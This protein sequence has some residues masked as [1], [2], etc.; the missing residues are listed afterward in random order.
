[1][2]GS[3]RDIVGDAVEDLEF[4]GPRIDIHISASVICGSRMISSISSSN[5]ESCVISIGRGNC[6]I[7][8]D[9]PIDGVGKLTGGR[10][11]VPGLALSS[12]PGN[13]RSI[14]LGDCPE[15]LGLV[16]GS[17]V[18]SNKLFKLLVT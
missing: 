6:S 7:M 15:K 5:V 9:I 4:T 16:V 8:G 11:T 3:S 12:D 10:L 17:G 18:S 2:K 13:K 14:N 1:L